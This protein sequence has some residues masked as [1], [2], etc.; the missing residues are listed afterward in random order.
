MACKNADNAYKIP[1]F[2]LTGYCCKTNIPSTTAFRGFG[3]PQGMVVTETWMTEVANYCGISQT[4]V[5]L[6]VGAIHDR[7]RA[8]Y[9]V[10]ST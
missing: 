5:S 7:S 1:N 10:I 3:A 8:I 4:K 6:N 2:K 9:T